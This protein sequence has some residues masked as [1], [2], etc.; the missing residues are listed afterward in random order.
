MGVGTGLMKILLFL[1]NVV[2]F[3][4]GIAL[5]VIGAISRGVTEEWKE[6]QGSAHIITTASTILIVAG[7]IVTFIAFMGCCGAKKESECLLFTYAVCLVVVFTIELG[8]GIY[9]YTKTDYMKNNVAKTI[10]DAV[11]D[12]YGTKDHKSITEAVDWFQ[13]YAECCG[14][15]KP[16][17]WNSSKWNEMNKTKEA[18]PESCCVD[19]RKGCNMGEMKTLMTSG[20]I[21]TE[22]CVSKG[23]DLVDKALK[24]IGGMAVAMCPL[25]M[26][27]I[28]LSFFLFFELS[29]KWHW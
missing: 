4:L 7:S 16:S 15:E 12:K 18:V 26:V 14:G 13:D 20:K 17:D 10:E 23:K 25:Q 5:L 8:A 2:F 22:G 21:Y 19:Q 24:L 1:F 29:A 9:A 28:P 11:R 6:L 27:G 3:I